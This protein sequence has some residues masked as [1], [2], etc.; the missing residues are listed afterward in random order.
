MSRSDYVEVFSTCL[1]SGFEDVW[2]LSESRHLSCFSRIG[3][4]CFGLKWTVDIEQK[5][6]CSPETLLIEF[7]NI[8]S[9]FLYLVIQRSKWLSLPLDRC[10]W[11]LSQ[12][13]KVWYVMICFCP[14]LSQKSEVFL[15][16]IVNN[17]DKLAQAKSAG[18]WAKIPRRVPS[19][20]LNWV[21][22]DGRFS[23]KRSRVEYYNY[24]HLGNMPS[25]A[26]KRR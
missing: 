23:T 14:I 16:H 4:I 24:K 11:W 18:E 10:P 12:L 25:L 26:R 17:Y 8:K 13:Q 2:G 20:S 15:E 9:Y 1:S 19:T 3:L 6:T 5:L 7:I 22:R 21:S